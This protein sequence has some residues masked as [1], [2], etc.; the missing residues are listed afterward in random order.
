MT[1]FCSTIFTKH[2]KDNF[3]L[4]VMCCLPV[5]PFYFSADFFI[6]YCLECDFENVQGIGNC[7]FLIVSVLILVCFA[8]FRYSLEGYIKKHAE[9]YNLLLILGISNKDFWTTLCKEYCPLFIFSI[10]FIVIL[11]SV[12]SNIVLT[13]IFKIS[14]QNMVMVS[15]IIFGIILCLFVFVMLGTLII[16]KWKQ[17]KVCLVEYMEGL[18][19]GTEK[20]HRDCI[21]YGISEYAAFICFTISLVLLAKY[22]VGKMMLSVLLHIVGVYF[23]LQ[24][25]GHVIKKLFSK[26]K[27]RYFEKLLSWVDFISEYRLNG[28]MICAIYSVNLLFSF[29]FGGLFASNTSSDNVFIGIE[30]LFIILALSIVLEAQ[31]IILEKLFIDIKNDIKQREI[32][33]NLGIQSYDYESFLRGRIKKLFLLPGV[34]ASIMGMFFFFCD[35]IYQEKVSKLSQLW[36]VEVIKYLSVV[37]FFWVLQFGGYLYAKKRVLRQDK[38]RN[39]GA[40]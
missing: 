11:S 19:N 28:S 30:I 23:L 4:Y 3:E 31:V 40:N 5:F 18:S 24:V 27:Q 39:G 16:M 9:K 6:Y 26:N 20:K 10:I 7:L 17:S 12:I 8:I 37:L 29:V 35:Y 22:S 32:L 2:V 33:F 15:A 25:N 13:S 36:N 34:M 14:F 38:Y 21:S 1:D